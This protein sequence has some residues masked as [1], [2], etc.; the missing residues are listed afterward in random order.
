MIYKTPRLVL[1]KLRRRWDKR[2]HQSGLDRS[3]SI[4]NFGDSHFL[5]VGG[6]E[7]Q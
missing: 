2:E 1:G 6:N 4:L 7:R 3:Q 5:G